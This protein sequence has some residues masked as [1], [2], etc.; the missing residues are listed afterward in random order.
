MFPIYM[1]KVVWCRFITFGKGLRQNEPCSRKPKQRMF[2]T[3]RPCSMFS[4]K[5]NYTQMVSIFLKVNVHSEN[6]I[7][8]CRSDQNTRMHK[9]IYI[10]T[11][12]FLFFFIQIIYFKI[13]QFR[14]QYVTI[15]E[16]RIKYPSF[17][18]HKKQNSN[19]NRS[20]VNRLY[21][22]SSRHI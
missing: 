10:N 12:L 8:Y 15:H 22:I 2:M 14:A 20:F 17:F 19:C 7:Y 4:D 6:Q 16:E 18:L 9:W 3:S 11:F 5:K 1:F 21:I 13:V